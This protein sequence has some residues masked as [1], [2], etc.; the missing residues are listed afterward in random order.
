MA[1]KSKKAK[2]SKPASTPKKAAGSKKPAV[3]SSKAKSVAAAPK[4]TAA[5]PAKKAAA[6]AKAAPT[7]TVA[8]KTAAPAPASKIKTTKSG[9]KQEVSLKAKTSKASESS[10]RRSQ[11]AAFIEAALE[12][13]EAEENDDDDEFDPEAFLA[14][15]GGKGLIR[16]HT[17]RKERVD[18]NLPVRYRHPKGPMV[19]NAILVNLSKTGLCLESKEKL[20]D[21]TVLR[22]EIPLPHTSELFAIQAE[23]IWTEKAPESATGKNATFHLGMN[24]LAMSLAKKTVINNFIQQRR[25]EIVMAKIGLDRFSESVPVAGLD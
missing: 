23:V 1:A 12:D 14:A 10:S 7:K 24:F 2:P 16:S 21:K 20:K 5:A 17:M 15:S 11:A 8:A 6:P 25:D 4:K 22:I 19:F 3:K 9:L 18:L 13:E